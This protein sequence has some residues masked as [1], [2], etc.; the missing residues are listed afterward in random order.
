MANEELAVAQVREVAHIKS[1]GGGD[2]VLERED[3]AQVDVAVHRLGAG[4]GE[5]ATDLA[6]LPPAKWCWYTRSCFV[7]VLPVPS[8]PGSPATSLSTMTM[9]AAM[10]AVMILGR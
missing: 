2:G 10:G 8:Q 4:P 3:P 9:V 5:R 6:G 1:A 7:E